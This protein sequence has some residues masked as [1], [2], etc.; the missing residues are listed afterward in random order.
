MVLYSMVTILQWRKRGRKEGE[1]IESYIFYVIY[2]MLLITKVLWTH[3]TKS[4]VGKYSVCGVFVGEEFSRE[5][6]ILTLERGRP[7]DGGL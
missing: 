5:H 4:L 6:Q 7:L 1:D 3:A 2:K